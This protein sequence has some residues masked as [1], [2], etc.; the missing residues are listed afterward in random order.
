MPVPWKPDIANI[1]KL[2][3]RDSP[4]SWEAAP[5]TDWVANLDPARNTRTS[6]T[7]PSSPGGSPKGNKKG[8]FSKPKKK[9]K[10]KAK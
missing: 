4:G 10:N 2:G 8:S 5:D 1:E 9:E 3:K 7:V 6:T